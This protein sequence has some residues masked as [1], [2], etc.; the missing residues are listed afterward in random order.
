MSARRARQSV[1]TRDLFST[2]TFGPGHVVGAG[3]LVLGVAGLVKMF[4]SG[5]PSPV[6]TIGTTRGQYRKVP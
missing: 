4:A 1:V 6:R 5:V 3:I 2:T